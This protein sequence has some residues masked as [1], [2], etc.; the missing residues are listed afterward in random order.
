MEI[1][2]SHSQLYHPSVTDLASQCNSSANIL[3]VFHGQTNCHQLS[4]LPNPETSDSES[5]PKRQAKSFAHTQRSLRADKNRDMHLHFRDILSVN[6]T[7]SFHKQ[8]RPNVTWASHKFPPNLMSP[9]KQDTSHSSSGSSSTVQSPGQVRQGKLV[10]KSLNQVSSSR[11]VADNKVQSSRNKIVSHTGEI[12]SSLVHTRLD[13]PELSSSSLSKLTPS[14]IKTIKESKGKPH[15]DYAGNRQGDKQ[16]KHL[17]V[18]PGIRKRHSG[19]KQDSSLTLMP[20]SKSLVPSVGIV[21][22]VKLSQKP[23]R[24]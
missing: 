5:L 15:I 18:A 2:T 11:H 23:L 4:H 21:S 1:D 9:M 6:D 20:T 19:M 16:M 8:T 3:E 22:R 14:T 7:Q 13:N 12:T 17:P 24:L 10:S